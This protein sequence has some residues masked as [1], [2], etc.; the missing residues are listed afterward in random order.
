MVAHLTVLA[1]KSLL[2]LG[3]VPVNGFLNKTR[4]LKMKSIFLR[5]HIAEL[6]AVL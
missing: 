3:L 2:A 1:T 4:A 5:I 6:L